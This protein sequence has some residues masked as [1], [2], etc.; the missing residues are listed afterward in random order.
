MA[1]ME[2]LELLS[3][4][5]N[6]YLVGICG[7][8]A[9]FGFDFLHTMIT[10]TAAVRPTP[11]RFS[12]CVQELSMTL[13]EL[14]AHVVRLSGY[15]PPVELYVTRI[16]SSSDVM[17][18]A[19][20][21][22]QLHQPEIQIQAIAMSCAFIEDTEFKPLLPRL[23]DFLR[24]I[25]KDIIENVELYS[26]STLALA[27]IT[28]MQKIS[29]FLDTS[30]NDACALADNLNSSNVDELISTSEKYAATFAMMRLEQIWLERTSGMA[31]DDKLD[32][33]GTLGEQ[34]ALI[35]EWMNESMRKLESF[36][37]KIN[38]L[39]NVWGQSEAPPE[40]WHMLFLVQQ[41]LNDL[42]DNM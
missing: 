4:T 40:D 13:V 42:Y 15:E 28:I 33:V 16:Y 18:M 31:L 26:G 41:S 7:K 11:D 9:S 34:L 39:I 27:D 35:I 29:A 36:Y 37:K 24:K 23:I 8:L 14:L 1:K 22:I 6:A 12:H 32:V 17:D 20:S 19:R 30:V 10:T 21:M 3:R 2:E 38:V 5:E 25:I